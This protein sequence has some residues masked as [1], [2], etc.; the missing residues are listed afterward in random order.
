MSI[1]AAGAVFADPPLPE[2]CF[3]ER[4]TIYC[5]EQGKEPKFSEENSK[6]GS[7]RFWHQAQEEYDKPGQTGSD[8]RAVQVG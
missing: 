6:E 1:R 2:G 7:F 3:K 8:P 5:T 4:G